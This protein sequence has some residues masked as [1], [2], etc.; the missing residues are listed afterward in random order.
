ME[1]SRE[2]DWSHRSR[3]RS[4]SDVCPKVVKGIFSFCA[5]GTDDE[6][7]QSLERKTYND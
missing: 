7:R 5:W 6:D 3:F 1:R 2:D 4:G